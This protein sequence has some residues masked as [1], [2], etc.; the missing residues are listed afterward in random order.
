M[1]VMLGVY[2]VAFLICYMRSLKEVTSGWHIYLIT[3]SGLS[4]VNNLEELQ[5]RW[6]VW[7]GEISQAQTEHNPL[8]P[9]HH[10]P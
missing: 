1:V 5:V 7:V 8:K 9:P 4:A 2:L 6:R 3:L 10:T